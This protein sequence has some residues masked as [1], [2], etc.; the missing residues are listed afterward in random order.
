MCQEIMI[1][2]CADIIMLPGRR[3]THQWTAAVRRPLP[4]VVGQPKLVQQ[5]SEVVGL[6][7][8]ALPRRKD[9]GRRHQ[10]TQ[11]RVEVE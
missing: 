10:D 2:A 7:A 9:P 5:S 1:C 11:R 4:L 8:A 3:K 6:D